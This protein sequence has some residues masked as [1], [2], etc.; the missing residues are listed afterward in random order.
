MKK[1]RVIGLF[2]GSLLLGLVQTRAQGKLDKKISVNIH[3]RPLS[4]ALTEIGRKGEFSFSYNTSILNGDSLVNVQAGETPIRQILD[5][6]LGSNYEFSES[7]KY[8]IILPR[9]NAP[10]APIKIYTISGYVKDETSKEKVGDV[11]VYE[12]AQLVSALTDTNGFFRLRLKSGYAHATLIISK[13][14]YRDTILLVQPGHDQQFTI[15]IAHEKVA[16]L[17]PL[18][19]TNR[20]EKTWLSRLFLSYRSVVQS[21]NLKGFFTDKPIQFSLVPGLG[22]HGRMGAQVINKFSLNLVGGYTAGSNGLELAGV[23]NIDKKAVKYVQVAG[24]GNIVG[25]TVSGVQLAG[26]HNQDLDSVRGVQAAGISNMVGGS[27]TGVQLAGIA[28]VVLK[29]T[30]G[31]QAAG[32]SNLTLDS[33][34]GV[35]LAGIVNGSKTVSGLQAS[36]ILNYTK[37]LKGVQIGL[38][39]IADSSDGFMIG[40]VNIVKNGLHE[41]TLSSNEMLPFNIAYKAGSH[42]MYSI[43]QVGFTPENNEKV[44]A[45]GFGIGNEL[46]LSRHLVLNT[47]LS[48]TNFLVGKGRELPEV[49]RLQTLMRVK[50]G[51]KISL[52]AG[53]ALS[54]TSPNKPHLP[55]GYKTVLPR[56]G[57]HTIAIGNAMAWV[58]WTA[59]INIF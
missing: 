7:G 36:G 19:V 22:T 30:R 21:L 12:S 14:F 51:K 15:D 16:D 11:S 8:V 26:I 32:I 20:V 4:Q 3:G 46:S 34:K 52:F 17:T 44:F 54:L 1:L 31:V 25:G 33:V 28:N 24:I 43:L 23:A 47:E 18:V 6:L 56:A 41:I 39:N 35:Q 5:Q 29:N 37:R 55:D 10:P 49:A 40:L 58:G 13:Q 9:P 27:A 2:I 59:G 38:I 53:P 48:C 42:K 57:Y 45:Y 50:L